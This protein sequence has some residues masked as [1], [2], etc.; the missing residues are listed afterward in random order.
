MKMIIVVT[1][2]FLSLT[3]AGLAQAAQ[4]NR[5]RNI[6]ADLDGV[7]EAPVN[8]TPATGTF[9]GTISSDESSIT[10]T[11]TYSGLQGTVTQAH[12]HVGQ[13]NVA[14]GIV[15]WLCGTASNPGPAGTQTCPG[16]QSGTITGTIHPEDVVGAPGQA[17]L[18]GELADVITAIRNGLA[19]A[20]VHSN[21]STSGEIRGQIK[22]GRR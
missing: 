1:A 19:Y 9:A 18:A 16:P 8:I 21:P 17:I 3:A 6:R 10:Y 7:E 5:V 12:I 13:P 22:P 2:F 15:I 4:S 11:L 20:N 14:G